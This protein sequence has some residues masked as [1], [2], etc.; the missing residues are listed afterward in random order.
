[1]PVPTTT[2]VSPRVTRRPCDGVQGDGKRFDQR[3]VD[4]GHVGR[5]A[6]QHVL[7][8]GDELGK[9]PM[10]AV[11][12]AGDP[13]HAA[14]VAKI[15]FAA[16]AIPAATAVDRR[17]EGHAVAGGPIADLGPRLRRSSPPPHGP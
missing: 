1:M 16:A 8:N 9:G 13:Q 12:V 10:A 17:V 6:V 7:R 15:D 14:V 3:G 11:I 2:A 5:H 4:E